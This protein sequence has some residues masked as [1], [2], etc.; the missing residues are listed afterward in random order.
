MNGT[1][2]NDGDTLQVM[3]DTLPA[4]LEY[5]IDFSERENI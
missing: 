3:S 5:F 2:S 4:K 1:V